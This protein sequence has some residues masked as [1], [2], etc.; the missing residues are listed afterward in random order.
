MRFTVEIKD[1]T[2]RVVKDYSLTRGETEELS[3]D[4]FIVYALSI[5]EDKRQLP[6]YIHSP[7][8]REYFPR[9]KMKYDGNG[10]GILGDNLVAMVV[11]Y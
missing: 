7:N 8:G 4:D 5:S 11:T 6:L 2:G 3:L 1:D 10:S 9:I